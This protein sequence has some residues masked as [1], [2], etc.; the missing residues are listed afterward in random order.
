MRA[1]AVLLIVAAGASAADQTSF[2]SLLDLSR[3]PGAPEFKDALVKALRQQALDNG[4][5][6]TGEG[7]DFLWAVNSPKGQPTLDVDGKPRPGMKRVPGTDLWFATG[8]VAPAGKLHTLEYK[9]NGK[10]IGGNTQA[11]TADYAPVEFPV[12]GPDSYP[13]AGVPQGKLSEKL[14]FTS[15]IYEGMTND[16]WIYVPAQYDPNTAA[17][18][19]IWQDGQ[20]YIDRDGARNRTVDVLD[21]LIAQKKIPVMIGVFIS[22]GQLSNPD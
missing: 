7:A 22:P 4:T 16:Y 11:G 9:L 8:T 10:Q 21:N 17:A 2:R 19:M 20:M 15:K 3:R 18:L 5:A 1:I 6:W 12:F 13:H 14:T